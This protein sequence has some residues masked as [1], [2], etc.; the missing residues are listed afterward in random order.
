M[1]TKKLSVKPLVSI[2]A[3][4]ER[5][6]FVP[7]TPK[8]KMINLRQFVAQYITDPTL[9]YRPPYQRQDDA[10]SPKHCHQ[11]LAACF[12]PG[13]TSIGEVTLVRNGNRFDI[14]DGLQRIT[15][16]RDFLM[17]DSEDE[18]S[19]PTMMVRANGRSRYYTAKQIFKEVPGAQKNFDATKVVVVEYP[20]MNATEAA[21]LFV[22]RNRASVPL[23]SEE[24]I[25]GPAFFARQLFRSLYDDVMPGISEFLPRQ[26]SKSRRYKDIRL[27]HELF[28]IAAG[29]EFLTEPQAMRP[30]DA[31][32]GSLHD[33]ANK[34]H[35]DLIDQKVTHED[36]EKDRLKGGK[37]RTNR[38]LMR[39]TKSL[40][41]ATETLGII[42]AKGHGQHVATARRRGNRN[43]H[44]N[45]VDLIAYL[46][47]LND[48][49][50]MTYEK[51]AENATIWVTVL[52]DYVA[53]RKRRNLN[54]SSTNT[55]M[56]CTKYEA[57]NGIVNKHFNLNLAV[58][59][60]WL[61]VI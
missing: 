46:Y 50:I 30:H 4:P 51:M 1:A 7:P 48:R 14:L 58:P 53:L 33:S 49:K 16:I 32:F 2:P 39:V 28:L 41:E 34:I 61:P 8:T 19:P 22:A 52:R 29:D 20:P 44:R 36:I 55:S 40:R 15:C 56:M 10:W 35:L 47:D 57:L 3:S 42:L 12:T 59:T 26:A 27:V 24:Q 23:S 9:N 43:D 11:L 60:Y 5:S 25:Y 37:Y 17:G 6:D 38:R 21:I 18:E 45:L 54:H 13:E 31:N